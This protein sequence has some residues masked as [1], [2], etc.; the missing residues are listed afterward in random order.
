[1]GNIKD[2]IRNFILFKQPKEEVFVLGNLQETVF[3]QLYK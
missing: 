3:E 1:M 2:V